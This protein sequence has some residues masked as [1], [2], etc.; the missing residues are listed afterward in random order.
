MNFIHKNKIEYNYNPESIKKTNITRDLYV[1][2]NETCYLRKNKKEDN[3][4]KACKKGHLDIVK[5]LVENNVNVYEW[6]HKALIQ[7]LKKEQDEIVEYLDK[8]F[9]FMDKKANYFFEGLVI[10]KY[11]GSKWKIIYN[12]NW[13][14]MGGAW[15]IKFHLDLVKKYG[16]P[17]VYWDPNY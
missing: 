17:S 16:V 5:Y 15:D 13:Q 9:Y 10:C 7:A 4:F 3:L 6:N 12:F 11:T 8:N 14:T 2:L 1:D